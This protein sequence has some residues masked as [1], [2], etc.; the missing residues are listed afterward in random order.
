M[1]ARS[2]NARLRAGTADA[3]RSDREQRYHR[4]VHALAAAR[5]HLGGWS[6]KLIGYAALAFLVLRLTPAFKQALESIAHLKWQWLVVMLGLET[7][8]EIGFVVSWRAIVDRDRRLERDGR[9]HRLSSRVAWAQL[10]GGT[11]VPGGSYSGLG[12]GS[13]MLHRLGMPIRQIT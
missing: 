6:L 1:S 10:G 9:G 4:S 11:L 8:S 13:W 5:R 2:E 12:V 3:E 7:L